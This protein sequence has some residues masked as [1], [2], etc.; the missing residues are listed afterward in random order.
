MTSAVWL[1][2]MS[3]KT[4]MPALV[5]LVDEL[6]ELLVRAEVGSICVKSVIQ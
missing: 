3:K 6:L 1:V 2:M 5:R 4:F